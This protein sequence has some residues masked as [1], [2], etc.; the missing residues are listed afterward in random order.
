MAYKLFSKDRWYTLS[1]FKG[2]SSIRFKIYITAADTFRVVTDTK[3]NQSDNKVKQILEDWGFEYDK[4]MLNYFKIFDD[5][6][7]LYN[8]LVSKFSETEEDII[9]TDLLDYVLLYYRI[10]LPVKIKD[11]IDTKNITIKKLKALQKIYS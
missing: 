2:L 3:I 7:K 1:G 9:K 5:V 6:D 4:R 8:F 11:S 10:I